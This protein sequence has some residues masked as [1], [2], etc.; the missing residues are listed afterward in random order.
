MKLAVAI[1][2]CLT[3]P[4]LAEDPWPVS[5]SVPPFDSVETDS[6][7]PGLQKILLTY[8]DFAQGTSKLPDELQVCRVKLKS[9][10]LFNYV[11]DVPQGFSGGAEFLI[12]EQRGGKFVE[13]CFEQGLRYLGSRVNGYYQLVCQS[14]GGAGAELRTLL[15]FKD[16]RYRPVRMTDYQMEEFGGVL[17]FVRE[18]D[19]KEFPNQ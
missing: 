18:R 4:L 7:P 11:V 19:P 10:G 9:D 1:F 16:G 12:F 3:V 5:L 6:L 15:Q 13:I 14:R 17:K 2:I 8:D